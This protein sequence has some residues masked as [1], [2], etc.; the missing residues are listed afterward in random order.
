MKILN[1]SFYG[2]ML[3]KSDDMRYAICETIIGNL[4]E[5]KAGEEVYVLLL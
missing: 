3:T 4:Q 5:E 2:Y 1:L